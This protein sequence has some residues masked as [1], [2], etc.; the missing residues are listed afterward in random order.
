MGPAD[1]GLRSMATRHLLGD[2]MDSAAAEVD[3][4]D[5]GDGDE[6]SLGESSLQDN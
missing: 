2:A 3:I 1:H 5:V 4:F 6:R